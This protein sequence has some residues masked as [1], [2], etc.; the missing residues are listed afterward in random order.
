[1]DTKSA[2]QRK[3][4]SLWSQIAFGMG[5]GGCNCFSAFVSAFVLIYMTDAVG[6]NAGV[7]GTLMMLSRL[8]DGIS[9]VLFGRIMDKTHTKLGKA[10]PWFIGSAFPLAISTV[11]LFMIPNSASS[12]IQYVYF[13]IIYTFA[14][15]ICYTA[16]N[17]SYT[18]LVALA[19][20]NPNDEETFGDLDLSFADAVRPDILRA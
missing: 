12:T 17:I 9:D 4:L 1:M 15:A 14:N 11:L 20:K 3:Y 13:F 18:S 10:R 7:I 8:L 16:N 19:T 2:E 5:D 6:M